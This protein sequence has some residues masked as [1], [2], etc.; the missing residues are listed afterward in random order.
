MVA[1]PGR[2]L[3]MGPLQMGPLRMGPL[4]MGP[5]RLGGLRMGPLRMGPF[6]CYPSDGSLPMGPLRMGPFGWVAPAYDVILLTSYP[7]S[8]LSQNG[9]R[10][11]SSKTNPINF[12]FWQEL[13]IPKI[14]DFWN[15]CENATSWRHLTSFF[16]FWWRHHQK[17]WR[18]QNW[19]KDTT[20]K[21]IIL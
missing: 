11:K 6:R 4:R 8:V 21:C 1:H 16:K 18:Q 13:H 10:H 17:W 19:A 3:R 14:N 5:L 20:L 12:K 15:F 7:N 2:S 9:F